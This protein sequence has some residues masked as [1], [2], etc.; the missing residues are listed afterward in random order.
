MHSHLNAKL[1]YYFDGIHPVI[2]IINNWKIVLT[3][4]HNNLLH[5]VMFNRLLLQT[6]KRISQL[7]STFHEH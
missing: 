3:A 1:S 6:N 7:V 2:H 4:K 5:S